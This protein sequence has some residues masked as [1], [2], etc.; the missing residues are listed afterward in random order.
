[1]PS[2]VLSP[3]P[4]ALKED[5]VSRSLRSLAFLDPAR[6]RAAMDEIVQHALTQLQS[7]LHGLSRSN[8]RMLAGLVVR[9]MAESR[10]TH[11]DVRGFVT[12][13]SGVLDL[14]RLV[15]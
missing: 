7:K 6:Q 1:M 11:P 15:G 9:L 14:L 3:T 4:E 12:R 10:S 5:E 13:A 2:A 8:Q